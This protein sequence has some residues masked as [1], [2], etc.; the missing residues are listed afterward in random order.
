MNVRSNPGAKSEVIA[1]LGPDA[2]GIEITRTSEDGSWG[3]LNAGEATGWVSMRYLVRQDAEAQG[4]PQITQCF[5]TEPFW[6]LDRGPEVIELKLPGRPGSLLSFSFEQ[7]AAGRLDRHAIGGFDGAG[8]SFTL[9]IGQS[10]C[11][12]GMSDRLYGLT[13]DFLR[14]SADGPEMLSGCCTISQYSG[15]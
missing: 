13:A 4:V 2:A 6:S 10:E 11:S 8:Q 7:T 1:S 14:E 9:V 15:P 5:G 3:R 12:D